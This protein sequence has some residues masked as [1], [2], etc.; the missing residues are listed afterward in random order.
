[1]ITR[2]L[3][4]YKTKEFETR[5]EDFNDAMD[6]IAAESETGSALTFTEIAEW[7]DFNELIENI[8][9]LP[10]GRYVLSYLLG[11]YH[12]ELAE[13]VNHCL[14]ISD[15][16]EEWVGE[17]LAYVLEDT[18]EADTGKPYHFTVQAKIVSGTNYT[19]SAESAA[20]RR[21]CGSSAG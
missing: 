21:C 20:S 18:A 10:A 13:T 11:K 15:D 17:V 2:D 3:Q 14:N 19:D 1:M 12:K 8:T 9:P 7:S 5:D 4:S 6:G 16:N